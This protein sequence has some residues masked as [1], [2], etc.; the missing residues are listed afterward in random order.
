MI[1]EFSVPSSILILLF[2]SWAIM[3]FSWKK[4]ENIETFRKPLG[5]LKGSWRVRGALR[6]RV[7]HSLNAP[8][9]NRI[10]F[11]GNLRPIR[12]IAQ[13]IQTQNYEKIKKVEIWTFSAIINN[14]ENNFKEKLDWTKNTNHINIIEDGYRR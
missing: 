8:Q 2:K 14:T 1:E 5:T 7:G 12:R 13:L 11:D 3:F 6:S 9:K 4:E 10:V